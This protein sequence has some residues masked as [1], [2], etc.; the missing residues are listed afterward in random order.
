[1][2]RRHALEKE[3]ER[4]RHLAA[5]GEMSAVL[6]HEIRNPL[7]LVK[8][9]AQLLVE[10][11]G[12]PGGERARGKA[13]RVVQEATRIEHITT[14]L[15]DFVR[16]APLD[17]APTDLGALVRLAVADVVPADRLRLT[18]PEAPLILAV[19]AARLRQVIENVARN[20]VQAGEGQVQVQLAERPEGVELSVRDQGPGIPVGEQ[21]R[22]FE[23]FVTTR[24]RGTGLGLAIARRLSERHGGRLVARNHPQG[25]A[26]FVLMLPR[27]AG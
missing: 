10:E 19:D 15:L 27:A 17:L 13:E 18:L 7:A 24:T 25:G 22:I 21:E 2:R 9:N 12:A 11:L 5:L 3:T 16:Q 20:A 14:D 26:V 23:P 4:A 6:A 1:M 8:G